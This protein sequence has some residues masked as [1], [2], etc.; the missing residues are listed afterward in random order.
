M[1]LVNLR[2]VSYTHLPTEQMPSYTYTGTS[3]LEVDK[4]GNW[5][6]KFL[7]SGTL[8]FTSLGD[9]TTAVDLFLVGGGGSGRYAG[10]GGGYTRTVKSLNIALN[11]SQQ[12]VVGKGAA[13]SFTETINGGSSSAL[14]YTAAGG[15]SLIHI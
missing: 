15:L 14:G 5:K 4:N 7:S 11:T 13:F 12:I 8:T 1:E 10:G 9:G 2:S 6:I 3:R